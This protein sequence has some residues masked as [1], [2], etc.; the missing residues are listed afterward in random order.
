M[1]GQNPNSASASASGGTGNFSYIWTGPNGESASGA[2][3]TNLIPSGIWSVVAIDGSGCSSEPVN[4]AVINSVRTNVLNSS[5]RIFPNPVNSSLNISMSNVSA[6]AYELTVQN[7]VG[8]TVANKTVNV[9]GTFATQFDVSN[10]NAG[11]YF[12]SIENDKNETG[13]FKFIVE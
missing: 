5:T 7:V 13:M 3:P 10:L 4:V 9:N 12:L 1:Q 6:G 8:Q 2:N 11:V